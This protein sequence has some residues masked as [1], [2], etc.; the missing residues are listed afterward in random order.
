MFIFEQVYVCEWSAGWSGESSPS[1]PIQPRSLVSTLTLF[2]TIK[3][4]CHFSTHL[5]GYPPNKLFVSYREEPLKLTERDGGNDAGQLLS[6][7]GTIVMDLWEHVLNITSSM[8]LLKVV[9]FSLLLVQL[10]F[11]PFPLVHKV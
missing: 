9:Y 2:I 3:M 8:I 5:P 11:Q 10:F 7:T 1:T 6:L 4:P